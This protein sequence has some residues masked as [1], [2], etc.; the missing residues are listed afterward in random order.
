[1]KGV[2]R[3]LFGTFINIWQLIQKEI[4]DIVMLINL[5]IIVLCN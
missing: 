2:A 1:M 4:F 5:Y 3:E